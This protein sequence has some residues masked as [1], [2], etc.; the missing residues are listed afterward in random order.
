MSFLAR[1]LVIAVVLLALVAGTAS[2]DERMWIGFHDDPVL[3][4]GARREIASSTGSQP[5]ATIVRTLVDWRSIAPKAAEARES[6]QPL[7]RFNDLDELV[8]NAQVRGLEVLIT[9]GA[10]HVG[11]R[12]QGP[13]I[14]ARRSLAISQELRARGRLTVLR[15]VPGYPYVRFYGIWNE[16]NTGNF[17]QP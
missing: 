6:L 16:F 13:A 7:Y 15:P 8:R 5:N 4:Y 17:L 11:K 1:A 14:P 12:Q 9:S 2:A 3:R 10:P